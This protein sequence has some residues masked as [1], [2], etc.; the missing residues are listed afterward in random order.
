MFQYCLTKDSQDRDRSY[1]RCFD[2]KICKGKKIAFRKKV[3]KEARFVV[4]FSRLAAFG[5]GYRQ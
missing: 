5:V 4:F 2:K 3:K 1:S